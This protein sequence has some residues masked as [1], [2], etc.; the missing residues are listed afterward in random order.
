M[1]SKKHKKVCTTLNY[2]GHFLF[3]AA[4]TIGCILIGLKLVAVAAEL[5]KCKSKIRKNKK[6]HD[7]IVLLTKIK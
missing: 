5:K 7:K 1:I 2:I 4:T 6:Q 3:L